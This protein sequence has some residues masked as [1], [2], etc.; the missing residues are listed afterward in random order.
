[1]RP[2]FLPE[3]GGQRPFFKQAGIGCVMPGRHGQF[4]RQR[5]GGSLRRGKGRRGAQGKKA[6]Q[7][8]EEKAEIRHGKTCVYV[9]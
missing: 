3:H 9:Q 7:A 8:T 5:R 6:E 1:M 2:Q 4:P